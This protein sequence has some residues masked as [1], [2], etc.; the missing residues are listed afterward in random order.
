[1]GNLISLK[2]AIGEFVHDGDSVALE[3]FSH[4]IPFAAGHEIIRRQRRDL[5]LIRLV[6]DLLFDQMI[7]MGCARKLV[8]SWAGN[9]GVGLLHRFRE[10]VEK[11][12]PRPLELEEHTHGSMAVAYTAGAARLPFGTIRGYPDT[13]L[14]KHSPDLSSIECPFTGEKLTAIRA[15]N[16]DV[17]IIHAQ[18]ADKDGN[19]QL[20]GI[21]GVQKEAVYAASRVIVTV[22]EICEKFDPVSGGIVIP[23][24]MLSAVA[25]A[26]GGARPSYAHGYYRRNDA[27]YQ[28]WD[29]IS[30]D[31]ARF[32]EWID[33]NVMECVPA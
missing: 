9:P 19:V 2:D 5:T 3:G 12:W 31:R 32:L 23:S 21:L 27:F 29:A 30:R 28:E 22:E 24:W 25:V 1:M 10:A 16:P 4:L 20:W 8:F 33:R 14:L 17:T 26:P 13:D 6:P 18:R 7:G 15:I 11:G